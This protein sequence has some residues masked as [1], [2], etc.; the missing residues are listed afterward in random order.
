MELVVAT[1]AIIQCCWLHHNSNAC[2]KKSC[3]LQA[4]SLIF[5]L[6]WKPPFSIK[7]LQPLLFPAQQH[8]PKLCLVAL[9]YPHAL[10]GQRYFVHDVVKLVDDENVNIDKKTMILSM[11]LLTILV[12]VEEQRE[13]VEYRAAVYKSF[14]GRDRKAVVAR[15]LLLGWWWWWSAGFDYFCKW[16][17]SHWSR[18]LFAD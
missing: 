12:F 2:N 3:G 10:F 8:Y 11:T 7:G 16:M 17:P 14:K 13:R 9:P 4:P 6:S 15:V 18:A 1:C 5:S